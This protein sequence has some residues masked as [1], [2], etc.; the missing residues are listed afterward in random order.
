MSLGPAIAIT[1]VSRG[2]GEMPIDRLLIGCLL[3]RGHGLLDGDPGRALED[4]RREGNFSAT[5]VRHYLTAGGAKGRASGV[6]WRTVRRSFASS[7]AWTL[8]GRRLA[9]DRRTRASNRS[10]RDHT[11]GRSTRRGGTHREHTELAED[12]PPAPHATAGNPTPVGMPCDNVIV[13]RVHPRRPRARSLT[14]GPFSL[15][16]SCQSSRTARR[17]ADY[18]AGAGCTESGG[19]CRPATGSPARQEPRQKDQHATLVRHELGAFARA[20]SDDEL[21]T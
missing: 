16:R 1:R 11:A 14:S 19:S 3:A 8:D 10:A 2:P 20:R 9:A 15:W 21:L 5:R 17:G 12:R 6:P 18:P 7:V 13:V 4:H